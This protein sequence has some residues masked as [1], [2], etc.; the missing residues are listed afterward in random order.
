MPNP[1]ARGMWARR[2]HCYQHVV[3]HERTLRSPYTHILSSRPDIEPVGFP[4]RSP[5]AVD[6]SR[7]ICVLDTERQVLPADRCLSDRFA[8]VPRELAEAYFLGTLAFFS[9]CLDL[10]RAAKEFRPFRSSLA[11][12]ECGL[13]LH[14]MRSK[15]KWNSVC[16][17]A[18]GV[19][20]SNCSSWH[21]RQRAKT[22]Q[23]TDPS[24]VA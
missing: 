5:I 2:A 9:R 7:G 3:E 19:R 17:R 1:A 14:L 6:R 21:A 22:G 8:V 4:F 10:R 11:R 18:S 16:Q 20:M 24:C 12:P 23:G 15:V 13:Q